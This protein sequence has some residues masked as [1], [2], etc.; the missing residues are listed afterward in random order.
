MYQ[1]DR[2][3]WEYGG[4]ILTLEGIQ[5]KILVTRREGSQP[6]LIVVSR[7]CEWS[8]EARKSALVNTLHYIIDILAY[9]INDLHF[10]E[11]VARRWEVLGI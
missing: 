4:P 2:Y 5:E 6:M 11:Y 3:K 8:C 9:E 7:S 1:L 10:S